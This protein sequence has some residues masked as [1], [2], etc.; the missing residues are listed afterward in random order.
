MEPI[1]R[2]EQPTDY[3]EVENVTRE[4]FWN[5]HVPGCD[6]HYLV[7]VMR[8]SVDFIPELDYVA[9]DGEKIVGNIMYTKSSVLTDSGETYPVLCFGPISVLPEYQGMGVGTKLIEH[10]K[11]LA[12][13]MGYT[14][15]IIYGDPDYY[16]RVGFVPAKTYDIGTELNTYSDAL[17]CCELVPNALK[18]YAG[19]FF[20]S[21][22]YHIEENKAAEFDL[23]FPP[24][25]KQSGLPS[26]L[27][28]KVLSTTSTPRNT[29]LF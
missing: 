19:R 21:P 25:E 27:R 20:E 18:T 12:R 11:V 14:S 26:Q 7:H 15:I 4:A 8:N 24:K 3:K 13:E 5:H 6:E 10:T 9:L 29:L 1:L 22:V 2:R 23:T 17:L 28:F 16:K